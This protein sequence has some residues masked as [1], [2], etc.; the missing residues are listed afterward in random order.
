MLLSLEDSMKMDSI[1]M[2]TEKTL[3]WSVYDNLTQNELQVLYLKRL[4]E[5]CDLELEIFSL[6]LRGLIESLIPQT[7]TIYIGSDF[8]QHSDL[9]EELSEEEY[10]RSNLSYIFNTKNIRTDCVDIFLH[11]CSHSHFDHP[12][13]FFWIGESTS[14]VIDSSL[15]I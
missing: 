2:A 8:S 1:P 6:R 5:K 3:S 15:D 7:G 13:P 12:P 11:S 10:Q 4:F 9:V 14:R